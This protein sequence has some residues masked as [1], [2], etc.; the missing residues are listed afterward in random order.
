MTYYILKIYKLIN[1]KEILKMNFNFYQIKYLYNI[2]LYFYSKLKK[3][4]F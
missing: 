3:Q 2:I 1:L 4:F